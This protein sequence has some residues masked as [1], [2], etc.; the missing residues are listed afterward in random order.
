[1][2]ASWGLGERPRSGEASALLVCSG[3]HGDFALRDHGPGQRV[4]L[5][6]PRAKPGVQSPANGQRLRSGVRCLGQ[7]LRGLDPPAPWL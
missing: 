3:R 2:C 5:P 6:R 7:R 1:M 4:A